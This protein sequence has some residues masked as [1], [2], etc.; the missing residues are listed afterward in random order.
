MTISRFA[1]RSLFIR[2]IRT[3]L[4]IVG[5]AIVVA[6]FFTVYTFSTGYKQ[7]LQ[8]EY[9]SFG[10]NILAVP[11]GCPYEATSLLMHGG[12][13][14][15][16]M[17][18]E[19]LEEI[20]KH[21]GVDIASPIHI[22]HAKLEPGNYETAMYGIEETMFS[23]KSEWKLEGAHF[24]SV[25][26]PEAYLGSQAMKRL[27]LRYGDT[28]TVN[29]LL[30][31]EKKSFQVKLVGSLQ[32]TGTS[33]DNFI[34]LPILFIKTIVPE[35]HTIKGIAIRVK[36]GASIGKVAEELNQIADVQTVTYKQVQ[37]TLNDLLDTT[38]QLLNMA[39]IF[40]LLIGIIG[41]MNT[42][43]MSIEDRK[44]ELGM[45]K[46]IGA[47][48]QNI[49]M[50]IMTET[51]ILVFIG[52]IVGIVSAIL[53]SKTMELLVRKLI[54]SAPPGQLSHLSLPVILVT[55]L[56]SVLIGTFVSVIP[57]L[58]ATS[59]SPMEVIRNE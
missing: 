17:S 34:F 42:I 21:P 1:Y 18:F 49:F 50:M 33:D 59:I 4:T 31:E 51:G 27:H 20:Q 37:Y 22:H 58:K 44:K 47:S 5:V 56:V 23:L 8:N 55:I 16:S 7:A 28:I 15:K 40:T 32:Q 39:M 25:D 3:I 48:N 6:V 26:A 14:D 29:V 12:K 45:L 53:L 13:M 46:A 43:F 57:C 2:K 11:K 36:A 30:G 19:Q 10:I 52:S 54:A 9:S 24:S 41:L 38:V 35:G